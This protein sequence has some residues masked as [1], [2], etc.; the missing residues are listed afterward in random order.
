MSAYEDVMTG[1]DLRNI[2]EIVFAFRGKHPG[3]CHTGNQTSHDTA[4]Q[5]SF[6]RPEEFHE[7]IPQQTQPRGEKNHPADLTRINNLIR[8]HRLIGQKRK[9]E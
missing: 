5:N 8:P 7:H 2:S 9:Q 6:L 3:Y 1:N 4:E